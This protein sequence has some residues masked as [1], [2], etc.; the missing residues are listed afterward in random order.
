[1]AVGREVSV[2]HKDVVDM[3]S[4]PQELEDRPKVVE[5]RASPTN[6]YSPV[7]ADR[8]SVV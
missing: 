7:S 4:A 3:N 5:K 8:K 2:F 1:M 6:S